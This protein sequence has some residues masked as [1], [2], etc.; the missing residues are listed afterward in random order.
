MFARRIA[1]PALAI[2]L[3]LGVA[4]PRANALTIARVTRHGYIL[5]D[6][7]G[8]PAPYEGSSG[9]NSSL[10]FAGFVGDATAVIDEA[11]GPHAEFLAVMQ[12]QPERG[13][14]A[15][16][17]RI[18]NQTR[19]V[20]DHSPLG[21]SSET[22]DM[23]AQFGTAFTLDGALFLNQPSWY[24]SGGISGF[25]TQIICPQEF[26]HRFLAQVH[27][28]RTPGV[29]PRD[30]GTADGDVDATLPDDASVDDASVD[31]VPLPP[32]PP[33]PIALDSLLGR[34][35]AHWSYYMNT[36]GSPVE[37]NAWQE[38]MPGVFRTQQADI[39]FSQLDLYLLGLIPASAVDPFF[40]IAEP[41]VMGQQDDNG[42]AINRASPPETFGFGRTVTIR[43]RRVD[44][45]IDDV[46]AQNGPRIPAYQPP[47]AGSV[48]AG[49]D[50][51]TPTDVRNMR[52]IWVLLTTSDQI[53]SQTAS[54]FDRAIEACSM[55]YA[56]SASNLAHLEAVVM[57]Q[58][59]AGTDASADATVADVATDA[60]PADAYVPPNVHAAG[61]CGCRTGTNGDAAGH[62]SALAFALVGASLA[63]MLRRR[64]RSAMRIG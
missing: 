22:Y 44:Y 56:T 42:N 45:T 51:A 48:E 60:H 32:P 26:G 43:G 36:G 53:T 23:N 37:G 28:P 47:D 39:R 58:P 52:V 38:I 29:Y 15:F 30:A 63:S 12:T 25:G 6:E 2:A 1:A 14:V 9:A 13:V 27:I 5:V 20:G 54:Q 4:A 41:D 21:G 55:G 50:A 33:M 64:R 46:I 17:M 10:A 35:R 18:R 8:A 49:A 59:D 19:G 11:G 62:T 34:D 40:V 31:D 24:I 7:P 61:G 57:P 16:Y 3:A